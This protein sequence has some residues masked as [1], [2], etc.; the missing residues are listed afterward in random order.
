M[1]IIESS[2]DHED[3]IDWHPANS[4]FDYHDK[5]DYHPVP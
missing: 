4:T 1:P 3:I 2:F 5:I